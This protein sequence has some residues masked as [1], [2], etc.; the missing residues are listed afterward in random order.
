MFQLSQN[1]YNIRLQMT[2]D[3][4]LEKINTR[5]QAFSFL[6]LNLATVLRM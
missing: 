3:I 1:I 5:Q 2:F 6:G 4:L